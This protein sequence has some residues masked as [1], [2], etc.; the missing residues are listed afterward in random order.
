MAF[1]VGALISKLTLDTKGWDVKYK[2][3]IGQVDTLDRKIARNAEKFKKA[4][5][6][7]TIAGAAVTG[8]FGLMFAKANQFNKE[9]ANVATLIPRQT[10]RVKELKVG[11]QELAV[12]YAKSTSDI[13]GGLYAGMTLK[14]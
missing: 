9:M 12:T 4:G 5:K 2:K 14:R 7:I 3:V 10:K 11:V 13:S 8:A 1:N 6:R